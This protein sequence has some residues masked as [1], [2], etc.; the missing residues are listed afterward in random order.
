MEENC[1]DCKQI[2]QCYLATVI[3]IYDLE[4]YPGMSPFHVVFKEFL[5]RTQLF[6]LPDNLVS[7]GLWME[8]SCTIFFLHTCSLSI[9][10][11]LYLQC[12]R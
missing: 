7:P 12:L 4:P 3:R 5:Y 9:F 8:F 1:I 11:I 2:S 6:S 10:D